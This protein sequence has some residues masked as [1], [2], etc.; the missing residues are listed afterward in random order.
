MMPDENSGLSGR[1]R[2]GLTTLGL[3]SPNFLREVAGTDHDFTV[4]E[5]VDT[6]RSRVVSVFSD[7]IAAAKIPVLTSQAGTV[8]WVT[9]FCPLSTR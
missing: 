6:M 8:S 5:F 4:D 3:S 7:A 9:P 2:S 1:V